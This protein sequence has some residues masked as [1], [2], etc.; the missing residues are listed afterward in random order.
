MEIAWVIC[1]TACAAVSAV[2]PNATIVLPTFS[3]IE[4]VSS[5]VKPRDRNRLE[6]F[7]SADK[8]SPGRFATLMSS[9]RRCGAFVPSTNLSPR[10]K[11]SNSAAAVTA[12]RPNSKSRK[13][14]SW[15]PIDA[16]IEP[17][18]PSEVPNLL[19]L[20]VVSLFALSRRRVAASACLSSLCSCD[21]AASTV[22]FRCLWTCKSCRSTCI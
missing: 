21:N 12:L 13:A 16:R 22:E 9:S 18:P 19:V 11:P 7:I 6:K 10:S 20:A 5:V 17:T 2:P 15:M 4:S 8:F 1:S 3:R 14:T